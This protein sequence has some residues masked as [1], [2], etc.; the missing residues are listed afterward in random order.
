VISWVIGTMTC[1]HCGADE[2]R[3][4]LV[5]PKAGISTLCTACAND[6]TRQAA[7]TPANRCVECDD[8][9][10]IRVE[11]QAKHPEIRQ[12]IP[13]FCYSHFPLSGGK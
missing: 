11:D 10:V 4:C 13:V 6:F 3:Y 8:S 5:H 7:E 2:V 12:G 9:A 1:E